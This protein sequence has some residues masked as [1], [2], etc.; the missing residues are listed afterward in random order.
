MGAVSAVSLKRKTAAALLGLVL[1]CGCAVPQQETRPT[2]EPPGV[3]VRL[4]GTQPMDIDVRTQETA[5]QPELPP[6]DPEMN[7]QWLRMFEMERIPG[8]SPPPAPEEETI[9]SP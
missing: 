7:R 5:A 3:G 2:E 8:K 4:P 9:D 1:S 6:N